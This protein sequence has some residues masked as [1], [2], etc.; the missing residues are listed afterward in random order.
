MSTA[1][2]ESPA[3]EDAPSSR[4]MGTVSVVVGASSGIGAATARLLAEMGSKVVLAARRSDQL[5]EV[6]ASIANA[7]GTAIAQVTDTT[8]SGDLE[9][10]IAMTLREFGHLDYAVN[11][12]GI[13]GRGDF[14]LTAIEDF[15]HVMD[16]NFRGTL[17]AMRSELP[18]MLA[19]GSGAIV[20][21]ASVGGIVGVPG[22]SAYVASKHAVVG[23]TKSVG[24]EYATR[25]VR[26]NAI[27]PGG[28]NTEMLASGT[29]EQH[30]F[31]ASL[32]PMQR[33]SEP[34]EIAKSIVY[35]LVDATY[36]T[37]LTLPADGGQSIA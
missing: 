36:T 8:S 22:L 9:A 11:S 3:S 28:T 31:L 21:V 32:A 6:V 13:S 35:L 25:G 14:L 4:L 2:N 10:L 12:A 19:N 23:L 33:V 17:L 1:M 20:N 7:G 24:L 18:A 26:I 5:D 16:V 29:Q 30:D 34:I 15:D 37:G 27:A